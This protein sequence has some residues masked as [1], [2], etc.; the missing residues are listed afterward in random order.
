MRTAQVLVILASLCLVIEASYLFKSERATEDT[1]DECADNFP[2]RCLNERNKRDLDFEQ[3]CKR[4]SSDC[5][6]SCGVCGEGFEKRGGVHV[7]GECIDDHPETC[8]NQSRDLS[9][10][11]FLELC[12]VFGASCKHSCNL[13]AEGCSGTPC[14]NGGVCTTHEELKT[15]YSCACKGTGH[16][17]LTCAVPVD[18]L[19]KVVPNNGSVGGPEDQLPPSTDVHTSGAVAGAAGAAGAARGS[20]TV[21]VI[22]NVA[23]AKISKLRETIKE[24][25]SDKKALESEKKALSKQMDAMTKKDKK[26]VAKLVQIA[27]IAEADDTVEDACVDVHPTNCK[28]LIAGM[29]GFC[30]IYAFDCKRSCNKCEATFEDVVVAEENAESA[31][32]EIPTEKRGLE[33]PGL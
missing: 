23:K 31:K 33:A 3:F 30:N 32:A 7:L 16:R 27:D 14:H 24:L 17:G 13:C 20:T 15:E 26:L 28:N 4:D 29:P 9:R 19:I 22:A 11:A 18:V 8:H 12:E 21:N 6:K 5:K 10:E 2:D 1:E 25:E